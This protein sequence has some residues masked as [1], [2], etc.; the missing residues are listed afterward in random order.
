MIK[1]VPRRFQSYGFE[2]TYH[3]YDVL[4]SFPNPTKRNYVYIVDQNGK[5]VFKSKGIE[6]FLEPSEKVAS[7]FGPFLAFAPAGTVQ[8][9]LSTNATLQPFQRDILD[10]YQSSQK[11]KMN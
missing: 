10:V 5:Q 9:R 1:E 3:P 2:T 8:V 7:A 6:D 11:K 4:L